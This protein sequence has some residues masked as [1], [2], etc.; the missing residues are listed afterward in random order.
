MQSSGNGSSSGGAS[1]GE[2]EESV[3]VWAK[4]LEEEFAKLRQVVQKYRYV[5]MDTEFPGVVAKPTGEFRS[6]SE[7]QYQLVKCNVD[8]LKLIQVGLTFFN[9]DGEKPAGLVTFQFNLKFSLQEDMY[10]QD[11]IDML[12][13]A[14][15]Q[16]KR[17]EEEGIEVDDFAE[18]L[19]TSGL[20]LRE[21]ITWITFASSYDFG[22]LIRVLTNQKLPDEENEF[23]ELMSL[24]FPKVYDVKYLMKSCKSLKGGLQEVGDSLELERVGAQH[25][26]GS[27]SDLTGGAFF[28]MKHIYFDDHI[29]EENYCGYLFGLRNTY[30]CNGNGYTVTESSQ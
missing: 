25:Q 5:A 6:A 13:S 24:Y 18:L 14:G 3:N 10:A 28:K 29:D 2:S 9:E 15:I 21:E 26:A 4:N 8:L 27:D 7:Y 20:V 23:F 30:S 1:N 19:M 16:F 22:Y 17:H 12:T 11:S